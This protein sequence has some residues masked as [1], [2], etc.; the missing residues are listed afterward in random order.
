MTSPDVGV[1]EAQLKALVVFESI[2]K[3]AEGRQEWLA[4]PR[5]EKEAV[6]NRHRPGDLG[7]ADYSQL[8]EPVRQLFET[9]SDSELA[10]LSDINTTLVSA[11]LSLPQ[12]PLM[13]H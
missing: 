2:I 13:A 9:L 7:D 4:A 6:F 10:L 1:N 8:P 12:Y 11:G 5:G 3:D